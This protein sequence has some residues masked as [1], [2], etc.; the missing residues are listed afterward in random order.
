MS[1]R[2]TGPDIIHVHGIHQHFTLASVAA[3]RRFPGPVLLTVHDYKLLCGNAGFFSDRTRE[4]C[5]RCLHGAYLPAILERCK[6]S[7]VVLSGGAT[8]QM[9]LW[10]LMRGLG[11]FDAFHCGSKFTG[12]LLRQ[13]LAIADRVVTVRLPVVHKHVPLRQGASRRTPHVAFVGRMVNH[14]GP[15][16]FAEAVVELACPLDVYGDGPLRNQMEA[17][18]RKAT[19]PRF[20]GWVDHETLDRE[21]GLGTIVILPY[22]AYETFCYAAIEAMAR[23]CC[24]V[25]SA[26]GAI[27]ELIQDGVNGVLVQN[28]VPD[29]F[30]SV[31]EK[32]LGRPEMV[33]R[34]G[35]EA[36]TI[37]E[38]LPTLTAHAKS[39]IEL[40]KT[41][42]REKGR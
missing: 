30:R 18:L 5:V 29:A 42:I 22:L 24:V 26:R 25:A 1:I 35:R 31:I 4:P 8:L 9:G 6:K 13:N 11:V 21:T 34:I 14:K 7:S 15:L 20:H 16:V 12:E 28:P 23:G 40:Y 27:P 36:M 41:L 39:M 2:D 32:L 19:K 37:T 33:F 17:V 38:D 3:L 10:A